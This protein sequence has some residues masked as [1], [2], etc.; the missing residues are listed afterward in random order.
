LQKEEEQEMRKGK[1]L[2]PGKSYKTS[3]RKNGKRIKF[4]HIQHHTPSIPIFPFFCS[5]VINTH[6]HYHKRRRRRRRMKETSSIIRSSY[7][8]EGRKKKREETRERSGVRKKE[9]KKETSMKC[10]R[11]P[12]LFFHFFQE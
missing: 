12:F 10:E 7:E 8:A 6:S 5:T 11:F 9:K 3:W 2:Q 1:E 4:T